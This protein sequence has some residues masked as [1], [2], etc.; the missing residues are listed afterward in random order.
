MGNPCQPHRLPRTAR[1][2]QARGI[3]CHDKP[4]RIIDADERFENALNQ[5][6][7]F[8]EEDGKRKRKASCLVRA[9]GKVDV[10]GVGS[11]ESRQVVLFSFL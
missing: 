5:D 6:V 7:R 1:G 2:P 8:S 4:L 10:R 9:A 3:R 11:R